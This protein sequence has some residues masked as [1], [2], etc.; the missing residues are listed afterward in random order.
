M[1]STASETQ[2]DTLE[3][4]VI[5]AYAEQTYEQYQQALVD[6]KALQDAIDA[7]LDQPSNTTLAAAQEAW[8][9]SRESY[10]L[11]EAHRFY[12]GPIDGID[13]ATGEEGP[14][15]LINS[16]PLN[17]AAIDYV[18][19]NPEAGIINQ[20]DALLTVEALAEANQ[21]TDEADVTTGYH[22]I[23]FLLWG[24]DFSADG[25]GNRP[26]SDYVDAPNHERRAAY[27]EAVT[28]K[29]IQDLQFLVDAWTP[30]SDNYRAAFVAKP[31]TESLSE[32]MSAQATLAGFELASE[33]IGVPLE[34]GDQEDEHSCFADNTHRDFVQNVQGI[35]EVWMG[36]EPGSGLQAVVAANDPA[37]AAKVTEALG[38]ALNSA[39]T[40]DEL[41]PVDAMLAAGPSNAGYQAMDNLS[42]ELI[43]AAEAM[44]EAGEA[45]GL[46]VVIGGE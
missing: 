45:S 30:D 24:Q 31:T 29:L 18:Q 15:G 5:A 25:P 16:W 22:A 1:K 20:P 11:T 10:G 32:L 46:E 27:L 38:A 28:I 14:E 4:Q 2:P 3:R 33:R 41:A 17:E 19:G 42:N 37:A 13:E 36:P 40:I 35:I 7:F 23:E 21:A 12:G 39:N 26:I 34:T 44:V 43:A 6:A 9:Y 8:L